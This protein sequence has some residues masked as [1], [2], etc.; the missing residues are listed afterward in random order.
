MPTTQIRAEEI[1]D[2]I[3][4]DDSF[5]QLP[6]RLAEGLYGRSVLIHCHYDNG[7]ADV[8]A[9]SDYFSDEQLQDYSLSFAA[10]DPW[11]EATARHRCANVAINLQDYVPQA[12][13][14]RSAFYNEY[15][16][17]IGDD[18]FHCMGVHIQ[19]AWG[20]GMLAVQRG[21]T[22]RPFA[23]AE[24][25]LLGEVALHIRH[26]L[27]IR[28]KLSA[29]RR[30]TTGLEA[31]L[32]QLSQPML[33]VESDGDVRFANTAAVDLL[34][35]GDAL[36]V[37][38]GLLEVASAVAAPALAAA[39]TKACDPA[40]PAASTILLPQDRGLPLVA[41]VCPINAGA[42]QRQALISI[43]DNRAQAKAAIKQLQS[44]FALTGAE[45]EIAERLAAGASVAK[46]AEERRVAVDTIRTQ[47]KSL[48][49]KLGC[50]RQIEIAALVNS[51]RSETTLK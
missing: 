50:S 41:S 21:K 17:A 5:A 31:M 7:A 37:H 18:T 44:L 8:L 1:Y 33:L 27:S 40:A 47:L 48:S 23:G 2:A 49:A 6:G 38:D 13:Y 14:E 11:A 19:R 22:Q 36:T 10:L 35:R 15:V 34:T 39:L 20:A 12:A 24:L 51:V 32:D 43:Q 29:L 45:A 42:G 30:H 25:A 26:L 4:D 3:C 16:R 9:H 46:I 28:G